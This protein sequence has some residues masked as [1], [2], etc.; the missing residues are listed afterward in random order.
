M[1]ASYCGHL[2]VALLLLDRGANVHAANMVG[3][4]GAVAC[5]QAEPMQ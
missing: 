1:N 5:L 2:E 3:F 4:V